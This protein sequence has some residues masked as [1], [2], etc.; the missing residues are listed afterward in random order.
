MRDCFAHDGI[1]R[2]GVIDQ[3]QCGI[4]ERVD[5]WFKGLGLKF[6]VT[7][8]INGCLMHQGKKCIRNYNFLRWQ[9]LEGGK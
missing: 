5:G 4:F 8:Q 6:E 2:I 7:P 1:K 3:Y 9:A